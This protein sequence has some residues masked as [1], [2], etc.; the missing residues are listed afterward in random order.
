MNSERIEQTGGSTVRE[1]VG[2]AWRYEIIHGPDGE[3]NY[4]WVYRGKELVGNLHVHHA[5]A[6]CNAMEI[7]DRLAT[8]DAALTSANKRAEL[9]EAENERLRA[10]VVLALEYWK[11]RQQRYKNRSPAWVQSA[12]R[13][14]EQNP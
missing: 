3:Q 13:A 2:T 10:A 4:A 11:H 14:L 12:R 7:E 6:I 1:L 9:A 5:I 8:K